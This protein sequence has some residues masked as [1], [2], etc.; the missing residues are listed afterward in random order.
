MARSRA[1]RGREPGQ[2]RE[3]AALS[4][5]TRAPRGSLAGV[6]DWRARSKLVF[7]DGCTVHLSSSRGEERPMDLRALQ[8]PLKERYREEPGSSRITLTAR[9]RQEDAPVACS[10]DL[11]RAIY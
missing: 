6:R 11:G 1:A 10:V 5:T 9:G 3:E 8:Q 2:I 7:E 4:G